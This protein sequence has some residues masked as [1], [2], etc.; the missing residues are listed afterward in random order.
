MLSF[1]GLRK[2]SS[3]KSTPEK[4]MD[5]FVILGETVEE[6]R[7][8]MQS[9]NIVQPSTNV[10]VLPSKQSSS[11]NP[12]PP[13]VPAQPAVATPAPVAETVPSLPELLGDVPFTLAP[14][15][16]AM[17]A[18]IPQLPEILLSHDINDNLASYRYDFTLE[19]SVLCDS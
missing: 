18:G 2:D 12:A 15:V 13:P 19:N 3:K 14:H 11:S 8:K 9:M 17:Q 1:L 10:I 4:E 6:Q 7:Q 5:G 16:L